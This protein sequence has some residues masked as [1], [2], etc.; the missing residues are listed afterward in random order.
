MLIF[1]IQIN[2]PNIPNIPVILFYIN[3]PRITLIIPK[4]RQLI[5]LYE[6]LQLFQLISS[7]PP[8]QQ[9]QQLT[10]SKPMCE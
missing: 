8:L 5:A 7:A 6:F 4:L 1:H 3:C 2:I 10:A 9:V